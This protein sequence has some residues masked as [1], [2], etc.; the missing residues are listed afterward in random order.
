LNFS[1]VI[2]K[3]RFSAPPNCSRQPGDRHF[4]LFLVPG[5]SEAVDHLQ[6]AEEGKGHRNCWVGAP[7]QGR[8][9]NRAPLARGPAEPAVHL[10][11]I[12]INNKLGDKTQQQVSSRYVLMYDTL[13]FIT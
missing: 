4:G 10:F 1:L 5:R 2:A 12:H 7:L 6:F 11:P 9:E 3:V 13:R 8:E